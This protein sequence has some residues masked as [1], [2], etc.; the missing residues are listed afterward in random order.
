MIRLFLNG[1]FLNQICMCTKCKLLQSLR[2]TTT[3]PFLS[4]TYFLEV[5]TFIILVDLLVFISTSLTYCYFSALGISCGLNCSIDGDGL[6]LFLP[7]FYNIHAIF[8]SLSFQ[9]GYIMIL[10]RSVFSVHIFMAM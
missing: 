5:I 8:L 6:P 4:Y 3:L 1:V 10:I 7:C 2:K 9:Y